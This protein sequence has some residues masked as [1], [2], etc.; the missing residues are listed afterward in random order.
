MEEV[1]AVMEAVAVV[2]KGVAGAAA[3]VVQRDLDWSSQ[4][5]L[6]RSCWSCL[7]WW[8][9]RLTNFLLAK[10][11]STVRVAPAPALKAERKGFFFLKKRSRLSDIIRWPKLEVSA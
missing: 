2:A 7:L 3:A 1:E 4:H 5:S 6:S 11:W 8:S 10:P 9:E